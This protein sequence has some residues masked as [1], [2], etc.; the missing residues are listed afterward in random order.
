MKKLLTL[1]AF[2]LLITSIS[3]AS[4]PVKPI[5]NVIVSNI[6]DSCDIIIKRNWEEISAKVIEITPDI[7]K[8]KKCSNLN[9]PIISILKSDVLAI[10]YHNGEKDV[11][12]SGPSSETTN[13]INSD[14]YNSESESYKVF[15]TIS[16][17]FSCTSILFSLVGLWG[18]GL[19]LIIP[20]FI[21]WMI[22]LSLKNN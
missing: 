16:L 14:N 20:A 8:Y 7:I 10:K 1:S 12:D 17:I 2:Y 15:N 9:G 22:G 4:F 3:F 6:D 19:L 5:N 18:I 13:S 11:F 21:F